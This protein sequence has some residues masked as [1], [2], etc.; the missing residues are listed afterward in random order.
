VGIMKEPLVKK[1]ICT[2]SPERKLLLKGACSRMLMSVVDP[3]VVAVI[4]DTCACLIIGVACMFT[5]SNRTIYLLITKLMKFHRG[6]R[7]ELRESEGIQLTKRE[8]KQ[9]KALPN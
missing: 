6:Y 3:I 1:L 4:S 8:E 2:L 7:R 5:P 9:Y